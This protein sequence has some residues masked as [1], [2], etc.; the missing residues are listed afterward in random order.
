MEN[1][2]RKVE[3]ELVTVVEQPTKYILNNVVPIPKTAGT[4]PHRPSLYLIKKDATI[5]EFLFSNKGLQRNNAIDIETHVAEQERL[6]QI[7]EAQGF[8][9]FNNVD[10]N[11]FK[12]LDIYE[13]FKS[14][15]NGSG[16]N[17]GSDRNKFVLGVFII[18]FQAFLLGRYPHTVYYDFH[19]ILCTF[20]IVQKG[21]YYKTR[22]Y[23][24]YLTDLCYATN[25]LTIVFFEFLPK[26]DYIFKTA[27]FYSTGILA[28]ATYQFRN[29]LVF[30]NFD[31]LSSLSIHL[32]PMIA[33]WNLRWFTFPY[34]ATLAESDRR[35]L[36]LDTSFDL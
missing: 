27:F 20:M 22:G 24:Y 32:F 1:N 35:F 4:A 30:H 7:D 5:F 15:V 2:T 33:F 36:T 23:H 13:N 31:Y 12:N 3:S 17:R 26:N 21:V 11:D 10:F 9:Q 25:W 16:F 6:V 18:I 8:Y 34:E 29:Q 28:M 19:C 14:K